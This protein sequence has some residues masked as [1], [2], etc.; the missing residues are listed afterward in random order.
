MESATFVEFQ[1]MSCSMFIECLKAKMAE[2][3]QNLTL[4]VAAPTVIERFMLAK[5]P[6][7]ADIIHQVANM[8]FIIQMKKVRKFGSEVPK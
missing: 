7:M 6:F 5:S 2:N 1:N 4:F 3:T 8:F